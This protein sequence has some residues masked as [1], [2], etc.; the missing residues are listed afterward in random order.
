ML[1]KVGNELRSWWETIDWEDKV[2]VA[3]CG[4]AVLFLFTFSTI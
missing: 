3:G 1:H 2:V 4:V